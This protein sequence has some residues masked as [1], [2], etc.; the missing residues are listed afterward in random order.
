MSSYVSQQNLVCDNSSTPNF[1]SW[2]SAISSALSSSGWTKTSDTGQVNWGSNP[3]PPS[4]SFLYEIWGPTDALQTGS[5]VYYLKMEYGYSSSGVN[6][7][8]SI[9]TGTNGSGTLT[10][11]I[12][13]P[14]AFAGAGSSGGTIANQG[15]T[16]YECNFSGDIDRFHMMLWRTNGS[17]AC[18]IFSVERTKTTAGAN[19]SDGVT[20]FVVSPNG[21]YS[22]SSGLSHGA[23]GYGFFQ[24]L[25]FG[26]GLGQ[27]YSYTPFIVAQWFANSN[28]G[29][30]PISVLANSVAVAPQMPEY[31]KLGNPLTGICVIGS[32]NLAEGAE[33]QTSLYGATRTYIAT[34]N[35]F[36]SGQAQQLTSSRTC[37]R[38]D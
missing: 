23:N 10:G 5:T 27:L 32:G 21:Y 24:T 1:D 22:G 20:M 29:Y 25:V 12:L 14:Y 13:G 36:N 18:S 35:Y 33:F 7:R 2:G 6:I 38:F 3:A 26:V 30:P 34:S 37:M 16:T 28:N 15:V 9:G 8:V 4:S 11:F 17:T 31:G 19:S